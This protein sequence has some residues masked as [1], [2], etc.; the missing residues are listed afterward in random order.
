MR[1]AVALVLAGA[2]VMVG[3]SSG[4]LTTAKLKRA[5]V[6]VFCSD[7][8]YP[9]LEFFPDGSTVATGSDVDI[10]TEIARRLGV[11]ARFDDMPFGK[12]V[13]TLASKRC[14]AIMSGLNDSEQ[15]R[16]SA[17]FVDYMAVGQS[18]MVAPTNPKSI[19]D[20][21]G[22]S[23]NAV[24][25]ESGTT[26]AD[27]LAQESAQFVSAGR[28]AIDVQ[29]FPTDMDA[30]NALKDGVVDAYF[31]DSP[32]VAFYVYDHP[33]S[34]AFGGRPIDPVPVGVAIRRADSEFR[35]AVM[36]FVE[37]MYADGTMCRILEQWRLASFALS[38]ACPS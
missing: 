38:G 30:A 26:N 32:T 21:A 27:F 5:G 3:C 36:K 1:G 25:V 18:L 13:G 9:P 37:A 8:A 16:A 15:S 35:D 10:G 22:L 20:L 11:V 34:F 28:P 19:A 24:S 23:G 29:A 12:L 33:S 31:G 7:V 6:L 2:L 4:P 17:D 14:D